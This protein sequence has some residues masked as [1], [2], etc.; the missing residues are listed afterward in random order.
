MLNGFY[1]SKALEDHEM[2]LSFSHLLLSWRNYPAGVVEEGGAINGWDHG[3]E[4]SKGDRLWREN[5][6]GERAREGES[7]KGMSGL[8]GNNKCKIFYQN[9]KC[10]I[11]ICLN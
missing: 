8:R 1:A 9:F 5:C 4:G 11:Q 6:D 3:R 10:K 2:M 7:V